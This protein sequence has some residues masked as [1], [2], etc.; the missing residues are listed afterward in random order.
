MWYKQKSGT[1]SPAE[2][3]TAVLT[4]NLGLLWSIT[5]QT[6]DKMESILINKINKKTFVYGD[7]I[8][9]SVLQQIIRMIQNVYIIQLIKTY[10]NQLCIITPL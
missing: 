8:Y 4:T 5:E 9:G 1:E 3:N 6:Y 2:C 7:V 10:N